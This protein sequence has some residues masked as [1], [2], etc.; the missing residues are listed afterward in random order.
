[1]TAGHPDAFPLTRHS[2]VR[3]I[4]G[5]DPEARAQAYDAI[6]RS[7][8]RPVYAYIRV[9]WRR[10]SADAQDLTQEFFTRAL[11][12]EYLARYD[13]SKARFRTFVRTCLD[14][15]LSKDYEAAHR[16]KRGGG[17]RI[18]SLDFARA[19]ADLAAHVR[20]D[21]GDP[22]SWFRREWTRTLFADAV[23][24]LRAECDAAGRALAFDLFVRYDIDGPDAPVKPTYAGLAHDLGTSVADVT[25]QLAWAR[26]TFRA[27]VL[28]AIRAF[29]ATEEEFRA[30]A[31]DLLGVDL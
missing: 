21:A 12:K 20:S 14:A 25:N 9:R 8:W 22:E 10:D 4:A 24:R 15:F 23:E 26:R 13:A 27:G 5:A 17:L 2:V 18:E 1:M 30:E 11:E 28:D 31:R 19:D 7:Y 16:Q 3:A 29:S 6:V